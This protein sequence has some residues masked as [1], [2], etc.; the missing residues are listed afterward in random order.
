MVLGFAPTSFVSV[1][2]PF[3]A[4]ALT[5]QHWLA[6]G[7]FGAFYFLAV[8]IWVVTWIWFAPGWTFVNWYVGGLMLQKIM[9]MISSI[10]GGLVGWQLSKIMGAGRRPACVYRKSRAFL[11]MQHFVVY[12]LEMLVITITTVAYELSADTMFLPEIW[13]GIVLVVALVVGGLLLWWNRKNMHD[14]PE[15]L[16]EKITW[17]YIWQHII[18][19]AA[20]CVLFLNLLWRLAGWMPPMAI[21]AVGLG[22]LILGTIILTVVLQGWRAKMV[23]QKDAELPE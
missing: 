10:M 12:L 19:L 23:N 5:A 13:F 8:A 17:A 3:V 9:A 20:V 18:V 22:L 21:S 11:S 7:L 2:W 15:H 16:R 14:V 6:S 4:S 1:L